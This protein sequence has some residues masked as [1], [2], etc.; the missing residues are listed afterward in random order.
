MSKSTESDSAS[1]A[2]TE[3]EAA[4]IAVLASPEFQE[5][6]R[7]HRNWVLPATGAALVFYFVYVLA[8]TYAVDFMSQKLFGNINVGLVFGLLQFVATFVVTM[9]YVRYADRELDPRSAKIRDEMEAEGL[10]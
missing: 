6:K 2:P 5:L 9:A 1:P 8:S 3:R 4:Y 10:A 7:K